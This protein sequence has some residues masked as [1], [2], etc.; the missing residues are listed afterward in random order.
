MTRFRGQNR[1]GIGQAGPIAEDESIEAFVKSRF[2]TGWR[3]LTVTRDGEEIGGIRRNLSTNRRTWWA[4]SGTSPT[5]AG[6]VQPKLAN[7]AC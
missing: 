2:V 4:E 3:S 5:L 6:E 7:H 1:S